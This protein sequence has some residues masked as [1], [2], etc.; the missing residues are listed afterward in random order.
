[1]S[2]IHLD[3]HQARDMWQSF[4]LSTLPEIPHRVRAESFLRALQF[5]PGIQNIQQYK[6]HVLRTFETRQTSDEPILQWET[7][8]LTPENSEELF[9][10]MRRISGPFTYDGCLDVIIERCSPG[11]DEKMKVG[12]EISPF[13]S[14]LAFDVSH[15]QDD[16]IVGCVRWDTGGKILLDRGDLGR[17]LGEV[18]NIKPAEALLPDLVRGIVNI[19]TSFNFTETIQQA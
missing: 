6:E 13:G 18:V 4:R 12:I 2:E 3:L 11:S 1:M 5:V 14:T 8:T 19:E 10:T 15:F 9:V 16:A 17:Q 7:A